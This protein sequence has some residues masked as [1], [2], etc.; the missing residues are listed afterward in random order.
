MTLPV[1]PETEEALWKMFAGKFLSKSDV[2]RL[3]EF[4]AQINQRR[5][6]IDDHATK[7]A[8]EKETGA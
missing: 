3:S 5:Y 2:D 1:Y 6:F 7:V 8:R 4:R